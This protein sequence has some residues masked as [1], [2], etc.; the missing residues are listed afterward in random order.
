MN[1]PHRYYAYQL[2]HVVPIDKKGENL[3]IDK[4]A[5]EKHAL[6]INDY[7]ELKSADFSKIKWDTPS[8]KEYFEILYKA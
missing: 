2:A 3:I 1:I 6:V 8:F 5:S 4:K 7:C